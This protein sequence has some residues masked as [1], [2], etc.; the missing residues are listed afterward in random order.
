MISLNIYPNYKSP[1]FKASYPK[2]LVISD[3]RDIPG[4]TC[5]RCGEKMLSRQE[6]ND[7]IKKFVVGASTA[8]KSPIFDKIR[9]S[10]AF[11]M[12]EEI[13]KAHP[14][15]PV[16]KLISENLETDAIEGTESDKIRQFVIAE[17]DKMCKKSPQTL[18]L[19]ERINAGLSEKKQEML[20]YM[21]LYASKYPDKTFAEIFASPEVSKTLQQAE[22]CEKFVYD[23]NIADFFDQVAKLVEGN[24]S[25]EK[26]KNVTL[27]AIMVAMSMHFPTKT[28]QIYIKFKFDNLYKEIDDKV[29]TEKLNALV[30]NIPYLE[31]SPFASLK[32][33]CNECDDMKIVND[34]VEEASATWDHI[35]PSSKG[36]TY[37]TE[38]GTCMHK[39]CNKARATIPYYAI[40]EIDPNFI[41]NIQKQMNRI[42]GYITHGIL[43]TK[44][45]LPQQVNE[46]LKYISY[47]KMRLN[48]RNF[49]KNE[50]KIIDQKVQEKKENLTN[51]ETIL[52]SIRDEIQKRHDEIYRLQA[53]I[54]KLKEENDV[55]FVEKANIMEEVNK[56][57]QE[58]NS[59]VTE[60]TC[61][62]RKIEKNKS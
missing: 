6:F 58:Y 14:R 8:L 37:S 53:E 46:T 45:R 41:K 48:I 44:D 22:E 20:K 57:R 16:S 40:N 5:A 28:K 3:I 31:F 10:K 49:L 13:A 47:G 27:D 38:N 18:D 19:L 34:F 39:H 30:Q 7:Y 43:I 21:A 61:L 23:N 29:L 24:E 54:K 15:T 11:Q 12:I 59:A 52:D 32:K 51:A 17:S 56:A 60:R 9:N 33:Y 36:G 42:M 1:Q 26:I 55:F 50:Q 25:A 4:L 35:I 2:N 62:S